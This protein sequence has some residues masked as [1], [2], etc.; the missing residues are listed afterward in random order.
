MNYTD[1]EVTPFHPVTLL[2]VH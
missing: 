1:E 2:A